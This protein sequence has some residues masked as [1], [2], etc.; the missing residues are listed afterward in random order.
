MKYDLIIWDFNGTI[1][2][3]V[4]I[5][6]EAANVV[7]KRRGM[8]TIDSVEEYKKVFCFP[9][10]KYYERLGF[11]FEDEPYEVPANE[12]TSEYIK[13]EDRIKLNDGCLDVL[14]YVKSLGIVQII[15]SSSEKVMLKRELE[16]LGVDGYF[17]H[18]V[19]KNDNYASGKIEIAKQWAKGRTYSALFIGDSVHDLE[20]ARAIGADC[21]LY[22]GGHD[23]TEHLTSTGVPFVDDLTDIIKY[24][25]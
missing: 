6:I 21:V 4:E 11:N 9:I 13:R 25:K 19:G 18:V 7:L 1:A 10:K 8:K 15:M 20:T 14:K 16:M 12:W 17:D 5:G 23:S 24:I 3:D 22:S 2:N